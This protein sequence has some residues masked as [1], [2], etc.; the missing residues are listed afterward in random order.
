MLA[1]EQESKQRF[2]LLDNEDTF[3]N[4]LPLEKEIEIIG[5]DK[6]LEDDLEAPLLEQ[7]KY[8]P[9]KRD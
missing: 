9:D 7:G 8:L 3:M 2:A 4:E 5:A 1:L 6:S